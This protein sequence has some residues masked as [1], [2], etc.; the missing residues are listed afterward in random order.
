MTTIVDGVL[1]VDKPEGMSSAHLAA[2][3]KRW[4]GCRKIGHAGTLDPFATGV[5]ILLVNR[6]TRLAGFLLNGEK[7]YR[8]TLRLGK[9][10]DTQDVTGAVTR[11]RPVPNRFPPDGLLRIMAA[12]IGE[13]EQTPPV[14]SALKHH[15]VPLYK[16]ARRGEPVQ[17]PPRR[18]RIH[19]LE[20][21]T[22]DLPDITFRVRCSAGTY[23]RTLAA[24]IGKAL[25]CGAHLTALRRLASCGFDERDALNLDEIRQLTQNDEMERRLVSMADALKGIPA[26]TASGALTEKLKYGKLLSLSDLGGGNAGIPDRWGVDGCFKVLNEKAELLAVLQWDKMGLTLSYKANFMI[27]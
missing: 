4:S 24:D 13:Q 8:G 3:V 10:T 19:A 14:F 7:T 18:I 2:W 5:M 6:A 25:G 11:E 15:G 22:V 26:V 16:L 27:Q 17:K 12:F 21:E 20:L 23:V 9:E 1:I